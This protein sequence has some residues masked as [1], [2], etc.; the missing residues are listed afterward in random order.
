MKDSITKSE[1]VIIDLA[2]DTVRHMLPPY[3]RGHARS[4][5]QNRRGSR[6]GGV[7]GGEDAECIMIHVCMRSSP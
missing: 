4:G 5:S 2:V 1:E 3:S 7:G 6:T